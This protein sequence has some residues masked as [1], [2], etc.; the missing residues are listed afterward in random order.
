MSCAPGSKPIKGFV[1]MPAGR[2]GI[3]V[4]GHGI[5]AH[6]T[7]ANPRAFEQLRRAITDRTPIDVKWS[8]A[9]QGKLNLGILHAA[10]LLLF[11]SFAYG[12][13]FT[14]VGRYIQKIL[15]TL[16]RLD[17]APFPVLEIPIE[18]NL[19][20]RIVNHAGI[21]TFVQGDRCL[22]AVLP[23]ANPKL[24]CQFGFLPGPSKEDLQLFLQTMAQGNRWVEFQLRII[25]GTPLKQLVA[26]EYANCF[27]MLWKDST[28]F[29]IDMTKLMRAIRKIVKD[30][31]IRK[32][33]VSE[34][35][36]RF[37]IKG[38]C[39]KACVNSLVTR[40]FLDRAPKRG[41]PYFVR[42]TPK[43]LAVRPPRKR[44]V[45]AK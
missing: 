42:L 30:S 7:R 10:H 2:I 13:L 27:R 12:Y 3:D 21:C 19:D 16:D 25:D 36:E 23:V 24:R 1:E 33:D 40:G 17:D 22:V 41:R 8:A 5:H 32:C 6:W 29:D 44:M 37:G 45:K 34:I 43:A 9:A 18:M 20:P 11:R 28:H 4:T 15:H 39:L 14:P 35:G 26:P 38:D 31:M